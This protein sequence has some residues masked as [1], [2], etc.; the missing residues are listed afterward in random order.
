MGF[1]K[2]SPHDADCRTSIRVSGSGFADT[3]RILCH[4]F[5]KIRNVRIKLSCHANATPSVFINGASASRKV[6][7]VVTLLLP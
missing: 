7:T 3:L 6:H 1:V 5:R 2:L 4:T